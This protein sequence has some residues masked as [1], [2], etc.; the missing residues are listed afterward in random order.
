MEE[1]LKREI[2]EFKQ[3][4]RA[5]RIFEPH[6]TRC[7]SCK[8]LKFHS[9]TI[10]TFSGRSTGLKDGVF[11]LV[12]GCCSNIECRKPDWLMP[13]LHR[14]EPERLRYMG[15][16]EWR[17][18]GLCLDDDCLEAGVTGIWRG[19]V[20][21]IGECLMCRAY[22]APPS[23]AA[24]ANIAFLAFDAQRKKLNEGLQVR[25]ACLAILQRTN[26]QAG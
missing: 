20:C 26:R 3:E 16:P 11:I 2:E 7:Q 13:R 15:K 1:T 5:L 23:F 10:P 17:R 25:E 4:L 9:M 14:L 18:N 24:Q 21:V 8:Q 6:L 12:D 22:L 19:G